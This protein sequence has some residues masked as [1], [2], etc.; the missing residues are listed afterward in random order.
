MSEGEA[1]TPL[2]NDL[3]CLMVR[4]AQTTGVTSDLEATL[5]PPRPQAS[6][7]RCCQTVGARELGESAALTI[8]YIVPKTPIFPSKP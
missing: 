6:S 5:F 2:Q 3:L 8:G 4:N 7:P 1:R